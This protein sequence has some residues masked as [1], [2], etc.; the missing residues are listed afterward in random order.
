M[1]ESVVISLGVIS[2]MSVA[3][4]LFM[5]AIEWIEQKTRRVK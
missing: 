1:F 5:G 2:L 4:V 3:S